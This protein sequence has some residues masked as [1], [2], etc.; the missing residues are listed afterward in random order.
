MTRSE[1]MKVQL[2]EGLKGHSEDFSFILTEMGKRWE[3]F[4]QRSDHS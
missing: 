1:A 2:M 4:E 3:G